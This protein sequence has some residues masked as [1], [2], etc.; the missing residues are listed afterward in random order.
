MEC[1]R[2]KV[3]FLGLQCPLLPKPDLKEGQLGGQG[4]RKGRHPEFPFHDAA[5]CGSAFRPD[6]S[7]SAHAWS[8]T[9]QCALWAPGSLAP[10]HQESQEGPVREN[11]EREEA[12]PNFLCLEV[13]IFRFQVLAVAVPILANELFLGVIARHAIPTSLRSYWACA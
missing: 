1:G 12:G 9:W 10:L 4:A 2:S 5:G 8:P 7:P 6:E 3:T 13:Y 11:Q